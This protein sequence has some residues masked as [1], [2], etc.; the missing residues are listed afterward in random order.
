MAPATPITKILI[1]SVGVITQAW[2]IC[3]D[4]ECAAVAPLVKKEEKKKWFS[5]TN[6]KMAQESAAKPQVR[7]FVAS[8]AFQQTPEMPAPFLSIKSY[9][10]LNKV[11]ME[12]Q[13][14]FC[15]FYFGNKSLWEPWEGQKSGPLSINTALN[16]GFEQEKQKVWTDKRGE[17]KHIEMHI[18]AFILPNFTAFHAESRLK[19]KRIKVKS[20]V[21]ILFVALR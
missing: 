19:Y 13:D 20:K 7:R 10:L 9:I 21:I 2:Q 14:F 3:S 11:L 18:M 5:D 17:K 15:S 6:S 12:Q 4:R 8:S 16:G 1:S